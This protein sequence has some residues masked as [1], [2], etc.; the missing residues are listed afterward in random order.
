MGRRLVAGYEVLRSEALGIGRGARRGWGMVMLLRQGMTSWMRAFA[1]SE[2]PEAGSSWR[3][4]NKAVRVPVSLRAGAAKIL[5]N[6]SLRRQV[7]EP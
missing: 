3:Q 7:D 2:C 4:S 6:M 1:A 5:V